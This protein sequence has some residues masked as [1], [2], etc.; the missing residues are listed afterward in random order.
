MKAGQTGAII[1]FVSLLVAA[2][3]AAARAQDVD[4]TDVTASD[5]GPRPMLGGHRFIPNTLSKD[6]FPRTYVRNALGIGTAADLPIVP[7]FEISPGDTIS[8][9]TGSLRFA[10]LDFEYQQRVKD[11]MGFWVEARVRARLGNNVGSLLAAGV[12]LSTGFEVGWMFQLFKTDRIALAATA[13]VWNGNFTTINIFE[14]L[15]GVIDSTGA[16]LVNDVP[17]L[18]GGG[19]L[20]FSWGINAWLGL[21]AGGIVGYGESTKRSEGNT[22]T[23]SVSLAVDVDFKPLINAP[24][25][26]VVAGEQDLS[27]KNLI[28]DVDRART[29]LLRIAY[30]GRDDFIIALDFDVASVPI[31]GFTVTA[32]SVKINMRY[33]F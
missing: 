4:S 3:P 25:G 31:S 22:T 21:T 1:A 19:G 26:I 12:T 30:T 7:R 33:Y 2:G 10:L 16:P 11:W 29:G 8:G 6:P 24:V 9:L 32:T 15:K 23:G 20:R 14:Y 17:V 28:E 27:Q 18:R 5:P 13:Q